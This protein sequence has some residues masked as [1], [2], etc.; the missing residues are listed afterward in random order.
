MEKWPKIFKYSSAQKTPNAILSPNVPLVHYLKG[1][2]A[3]PSVLTFIVHGILFQCFIA[4]LCM[5]QIKP[6]FIDLKTSSLLN[7]WLSCEKC[8]FQRLLLHFQVSFTKK[9]NLDLNYINK[10]NHLY[11]RIFK[12][13]ALYCFLNDVTKVSQL[14]TATQQIIVF[15]KYSDINVF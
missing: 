7:T 15:Q 9:R 13:N 14:E 2:N 10:E 3:L 8:H 11:I 5:W 12:K 1:T 6:Y 4:F